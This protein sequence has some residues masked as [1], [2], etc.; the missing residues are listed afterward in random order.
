MFFWD[1]I[2]KRPIDLYLYKRYKSINF[3]MLRLMKIP[4]HIIRQQRDK[5]FLGNISSPSF[6]YPNLIKTDLNKI[7]QDFLILK[8]DIKNEVIFISNN[9]IKKESVKKLYLNKIDEDLAKLGF[10]ICLKNILEQKDVENSAIEYR[11]NMEF[12]YGKPEDKIFYDL[13]KIIDSKMKNINFV[14][15][16]DKDKKSFL[17]IEEIILNTYKNIHTNVDFDEFR[18][19]IKID[20]NEEILNMT[21]VKEMFENGLR[22]VNLHKKW[23]VYFSKNNRPNV[24]ISLKR[25]RVILPNENV[26]FSRHSSEAFTKSFTMGLIEHEINTHIKRKESGEKSSLR[27]L[28]E[29]LAGYLVGEEG[30]ATYRQQQVSGA[31]DFARFENYLVAGLGYGLDSG[32]PRDFGE[33]L[34][35][36]M[37]YYRIID[38]IDDDRKVFDIAWERCLRFFRGTPGN[39]SG[40]LFLKDT[41]Y[42]KGNI[43]IYKFMKDYKDLDLDVGKYDPTNEDHLR[44]LS[45]L[46]IIDLK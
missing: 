34:S 15:L 30:L 42:R 29:G 36:M 16:S 41:V 17:R 45:N 38:K 5:V 6:K 20:K 8:K 39:I 26:V 19:S 28:S 37:D 9:S 11:K 12:I 4:E 13:I 7:K 44:E 35:L 2:K 33:I 21:S 24:K 22:K 46:G 10:L 25:K 18:P 14:D 27:L 32:S 3:S 40:L 43:L 23:K 31:D 1:I